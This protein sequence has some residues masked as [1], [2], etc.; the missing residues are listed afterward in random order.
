MIHS[1]STFSEHVTPTEMAVNTFS[2]MQS[3]CKNGT[4]SLNLHSWPNTQWLPRE[5]VAQ[6]MGNNAYI[7]TSHMLL[8]ASYYKACTKHILCHATV[9]I[10]GQWPDLEP[11]ALQTASR[12][13]SCQ[14]RHQFRLPKTWNYS[15][16]HLLSVG[17][18]SSHWL[19]TPTCH[20]NLYLYLL[21]LFAQ[22]A[23]YATFKLSIPY[24]RQLEGCIM[25]HLGKQEQ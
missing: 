23:H 22:V 8:T 25:R 3:A 16:V 4:A 10:K 21:F 11:Y 18:S 2:A 20:T 9:H 14:W 13:E 15:T 12:K 1:L 5:I 19:V 6:Q 17:L 24:L 7:S